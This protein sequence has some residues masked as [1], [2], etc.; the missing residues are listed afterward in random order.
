M[1]FGSLHNDNTNGLFLFEVFDFL[2][3][4]MRLLNAKKIY[5]PGGIDNN[6]VMQ[7]KNFE[8]LNRMYS[9]EKNK[10]IKLR[11]LV[12]KFAI[13]KTKNEERQLKIE[14]ILCKII[15][16]YPIN[17]NEIR[18]LFPNCEKVISSRKLREFFREYYKIN[19]EID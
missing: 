18:R 15:D 4:R 9:I 10:I 12:N 14:I 17:F 2:E 16:L 7:K 11:L 19:N 6:I 1:V 3:K 5:K 8:F 13:L